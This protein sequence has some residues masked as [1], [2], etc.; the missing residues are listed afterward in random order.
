MDEHYDD[1]PPDDLQLPYPAEAM[2]CF[3]DGL[4]KTS[5]LFMGDPDK[6]REYMLD[7]FNKRYRPTPTGDYLFSI[8]ESLG[9]CKLV[10]K[11]LVTETIMAIA[12]RGLID[13]TVGADGTIEVQPTQMGR[14]VSEEMERQ[15]RQK[16]D[17]R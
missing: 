5:T 9:V 10:H 16:H 14:D 2:G 3:I 12:H 8:S 17:L 6:A 7:E 4:I 15:K 11:R 1:D 13:L